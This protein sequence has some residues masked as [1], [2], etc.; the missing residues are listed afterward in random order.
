M[1]SITYNGVKLTDYFLIE[2]VTRSILPPRE[3]SLLQV[4]ARHGAYFTGA[5]YGARKIDVEL[6]VIADTPTQYMETLRFLA[7]CMDLEEP[8]ELI[9]SDE[10]DKLY[11]AI[12]SGDTDMTN[13]LLTLGKGTLSF[14]CPDPFA[15][16]TTEKTITPTKGMF[17]FQNEG[18]TTTFPKFNVNFQNEA[19]FVSFIS[20]DGVILIGN[21]NEPD[22]IVL[23]KTEYKLNDNMQSTSGWVNAG[24]VLD[25][26]RLNDGSII[27]KDGDG[28]AASNYGTGTAGSKIW[29]GPAVRKDLSELVKDFTVKVRMDFSSQD[30][31]SKL[32]GDQKGR[33][34]I[35]LFNQSGGKIGKLVMRD[36]YKN[37]EFNIPEIY[38]QNTT[39]LEKEP[40]APEG[41]KVKQKLYKTYTV[42]KGDIPISIV[43]SL[44]TW[45]AIAK[46][47]HMTA[48]ELATLNKKR[49]TDKLKVGQKLQVY[50]KTVTKTVY[51]EH[52]G[53]YN[54][55]YGEFTLSRVG[56]K[57]YAEVSRMQG[58]GSNP[59]KKTKTIKNT[60]YDV[61]GQFTTA[62]LSYIVIHFAQWENE[63]VVQKMRVT[64]VK[65]L[66]HNIDTIIDVPALFQ[67]GDELE[68]DLSDSSVHL[69]GDPFMQD[70]DVASTFFPIYEGETQVKVNSDDSAAT[71]S[72]T[73]TERYL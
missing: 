66:K 55:F 42:Q 60:F 9:I 44:V 68:V 29:H 10:S 61:E 54:D 1:R 71:F 53:D 45:I 22:Q 17:L 70:V 65:I 35:Y 26:G 69:N 11:Y 32:D 67:A 3:I 5:R 8:S 49:V 40:S 39:F 50:D 36:S 28:I 72:A 20:P 23:P 37:Y 73:F 62:S 30:G 59:Q 46:K 4:P 12:L 56:T 13:D 7:F 31:T 24:S 34:E 57:W 21:P 15:Y 48:E 6:T 14:L 47:H 64:D 41:K 51:P 58:G 19:T 63:P 27:V 43:P 16:S 38:I 2:K 18:T 52:V 25:S 33:L